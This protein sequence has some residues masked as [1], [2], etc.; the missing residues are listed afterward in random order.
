MDVLRISWRERLRE[1]MG[2]VYS[3][4][5]WDSADKHPYPNYRLAIYFG[6]DPERVDEMV[7]AVFRVIEDVKTN[8]ITS[9]DLAKVKEIQ[10]RKRETDL[11]E[12]PFW[13]RAL[14]KYIRL[15]ENILQI[16]TYPKMVD[17]LTSEIIQ[18]TAK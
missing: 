10:K 17:A 1:E 2:G 13:I 3:I 15:N 7:D 18:E 8:G 5:A 14:T 11:K 16:Q 12:N 9:Q 6:C 4:S